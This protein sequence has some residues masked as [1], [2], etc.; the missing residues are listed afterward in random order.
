MVESVGEFCSVLTPKKSFVQHLPVDQL[1][2]HT[3]GDRDASYDDY[4]NDL[5]KVETNIFVN[6]PL[7]VLFF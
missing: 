6:F 2:T 1:V 3:S 7:K 4:L 5:Q